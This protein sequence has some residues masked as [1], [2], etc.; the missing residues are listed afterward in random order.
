MAHIITDATFEQE[1]SQGLV[2]IGLCG[3][4]V[5]SMPHASSNLGS[6]GRRST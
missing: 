1:T 6:V 3:N 5:R 2:L 4:L